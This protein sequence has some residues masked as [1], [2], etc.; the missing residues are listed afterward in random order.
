[1][2]EERER[3]RD[4]LIRSGEDTVPLFPDRYV[5]LVEQYSDI[6][7]GQFF[8]YAISSLRT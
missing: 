3:E 1:M 8:G 4:C 6:I 5:P 2:S 7:A